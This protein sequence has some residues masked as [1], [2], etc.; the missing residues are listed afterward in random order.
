MNRILLISV[1]ALAV[2]LTACGDDDEVTGTPTEAPTGT[3]T[4]ASPTTTGT[5][6]STATTTAVDA[7]GENPDPATSE[8]VQVTTPEP[9]DEVTSPMQITGLIAAFEA[10]FNIAIKDAN[11]DTIVEVPAMSS[12]GQTLAPF[13]T[14]VAFTVTTAMPACLW[15]FDYSAMDGEP[16]MIHQVPVTLLP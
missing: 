9:G 7:C 2:L 13:S 1:A 14:S 11:G 3:A 16:S 15:V 10:Q 4:A 5:A 8:Q 12:E 6:T